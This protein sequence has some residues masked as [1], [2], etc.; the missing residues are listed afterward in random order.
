MVW[1]KINYLIKEIHATQI[2]C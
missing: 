1:L 2:K